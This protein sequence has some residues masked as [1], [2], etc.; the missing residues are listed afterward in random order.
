MPLAA[1]MFG[2]P[3]VGASILLKLV[4]IASSRWRPALWGVIAG[5]PFLFYLLLTPRF[6]WIAA[7]VACFDIGAVRALRLKQR[8]IALVLVLPFMVLAAMVA[9]LVLGQYAG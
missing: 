9:R 2:W 5:Y 4:G 3:A 6:R 7:A 1:I 8:T